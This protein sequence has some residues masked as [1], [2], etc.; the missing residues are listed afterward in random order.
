M[1]TKTIEFNLELAK[2][3]QNGEEQGSIKTR[4]GKDVRVICWDRKNEEYPILCLIKDREGREW[5]EEYTISGKWEYY[6]PQ[7][8]AENDLVL[9]IP[10]DT[11]EE[12]RFKP[13]DKVLRRDRDCELWKPDI[14]SYYNENDKYKYRC[15]G[16][17]FIQCIPYEGN[18]ELL[19]TTD[20]PKEE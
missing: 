2:K 4:S 9:E 3:I 17:V 6:F 13:F 14:F 16:D 7:S 8:G 5:I 1:K 19:G 12:Y 20:K 11:Q 10:D 15:L 18:Q